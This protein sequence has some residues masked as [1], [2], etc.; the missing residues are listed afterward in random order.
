MKFFQ[1]AAVNILI[2]PSANAF[3]TVPPLQ[4]NNSPFT[5]QE[6]YPNEQQM[7]S[8]T[9]AQQYNR[10][11]STQL[12]YA[13]GLP[14]T[15][16]PLAILNLEPNVVDISEI[17]KAYRKMA[18]KYHP[19]TRVSTDASE[20]EKQMAN[21]EFA[22]INAAYAFLTGK[23]EDKPEATESEK[24]QEPRVGRRA[25]KTGPYGAHRHAGYAG[26]TAGRASHHYRT[27]SHRQRKSED[28]TQ[29]V[30]VN[31]VQGYDISGNP[32][33][34]RYK[35]ARSTGQRNRRAY[36]TQRPNNGYSGTG[37]YY[38]TGK[39]TRA[40]RT[41]SATP[42]RNTSFYGQTATSA[43]SRG[44]PSYA[45]P[46]S[47][48]SPMNAKKEHFKTANN[49]SSYGQTKNYFKTGDVVTIMKGEYSGNSGRVSS[50]Y[51]SMVNVDVSE[52][53]SCFV[54]IKYVKHGIHTRYKHDTKAEPVKKQ[55]ETKFEFTPEP[56]AED[57]ETVDFFENTKATYPSPAAEIPSEPTEVQEEPV[58]DFYRSYFTGGKWT[59][60]KNGDS[61]PPPPEYAPEPEVSQ[62][63]GHEYND[64]YGSWD[65]SAQFD[66]WNTPPTPSVHEEIYTHEEEVIS[67]VYDSVPRDPYRSRVPDE[68]T[69]NAPSSESA[70]SFDDDSWDYYFQQLQSFR[71]EHGHC[72]VKNSP[73]KAQKELLRWVNHQRRRFRAVMK[74]LRDNEMVDPFDLQ[75]LEKLDRLGFVFNVHE[76]KFEQ[77][78]AKL[79]EFYAMYGHSNVPPS[80]TGDPTLYSFVSRQRYLY[81]ERMFRGIGNSL[82]DERIDKLSKL[83]FIWITRH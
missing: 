8:F 5:T 39:R 40:R 61:P 22:R 35:T 75:K 30:W 70:S 43:N 57:V 67:D 64:P 7:P 9:F 69:F 37:S 6:I 15:S 32:V 19:D 58:D 25:A 77:N 24:R 60:V 27:P 41:T 79:S 2:V 11:Q 45:S 49:D 53:M 68:E 29:K 13:S 47:A 3:L 4:K 10:E 66:A 44:S 55:P 83:D 1:L 26:R 50:V 52:T 73:D 31:D 46:S 81:K 74:R 54:E 23:S 33:G 28:P 76:Y 63:V 80:Y 59:R 21:D 71:D 62:S 56:A 82:C 14:D 18:M 38:G 42:K 48:P 51:K 20:D 16:D 65:M 17:K 72:F 36:S 34:S 12:N 78:L